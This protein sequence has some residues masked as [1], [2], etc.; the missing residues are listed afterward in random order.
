MPRSAETRV[1]ACMR[2]PPSLLISPPRRRDAFSTSHQHVLSIRERYQVSPEVIAFRQKAL[3]ITSGLVSRPP[4]HRLRL[5]AGL[6]VAVCAACGLAFAPSPRSLQ[7][8]LGWPDVLTSADLTIRLPS[9]SLCS[10]IHIHT[11][12]STVAHSSS[13][14]PS[15]ASSRRSRSAKPDAP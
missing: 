1:L 9:Q 7:L 14:P 5:C 11:L 4:T 12:P 10:P 2:A 6:A 15:H 13:S 8:P 3:P